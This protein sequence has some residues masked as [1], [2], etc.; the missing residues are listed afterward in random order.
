M[1]LK[2][3]S[4][5]NIGSYDMRIDTTGMPKSLATKLNSHICN[6]GGGGGGTSTSGIAE[7]YKPYIEKA[8]G[9]ATN[10]LS[11]QFDEQGNLVDPSAAGIVEGLS[12][13]QTE[14]LTA[15]ENLG[16]DAISGTGIYDDRGAVAR[17]LQNLQGQQM[18]GGMGGLGSARMNRANQ[19]A[20]ADQSYK[21]QQ[22]RQQKAEGGA[23]SMQD[24]GGAYQQQGQKVLDAPY[25]ELQRFSNILTGVAPKETKTTG[26]GK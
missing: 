26:G 21:F 9:I 8:L 19:S 5:P 11:N 12:S 14:G 22:A 24:V 2:E 3:C 16:R 6:K 13:Q 17:Q 4:E 7:E 25:T 23:Q 10:R 15:Q 1:K 20:L 18:A